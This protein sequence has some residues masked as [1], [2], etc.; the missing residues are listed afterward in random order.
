M[1]RRTSS[2]SPAT[3]TPATCAEPEVID[4]SVVSM[5]TVV[6][7]P[8]PF[9][10]RKPKTSPASTLQVDAS[11]GLNVLRL[12]GVVLDQSLGLHRGRGAVSSFMHV[13]APQLRR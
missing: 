1:R 4:S 12:A 9:G 13:I 10:P 7:L 3:S 5:R 2:G 8:A 11:N 6:D